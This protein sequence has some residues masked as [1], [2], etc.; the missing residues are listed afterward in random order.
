MSNTITN[1]K[2]GDKVS[3]DDPKYPGVW[4]VVKL[5][6][7]NVTL[8]PEGATPGT[9]MLKAPRYMLVEPVEAKTITTGGGTTVTAVPVPPPVTYY[10]LGQFVRVTKGKFPGLY[11]VIADKGGD[12]VNLAKAGGDADRYLRMPRTLVEA[13]DAADVLK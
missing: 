3:V 11:V 7:V 12:R 4:T 2:V 6:P 5:A 8:R 9:R 1:P 13:V 10:V